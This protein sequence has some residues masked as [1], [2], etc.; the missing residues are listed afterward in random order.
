MRS[1]WVSREFYEMTDSVIPLLFFLVFDSDGVAYRK[2]TRRSRNQN[3]DAHLVQV[4]TLV[5]FL[6]TLEK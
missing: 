3:T 1:R 6:P 4:D 5:K 2:F